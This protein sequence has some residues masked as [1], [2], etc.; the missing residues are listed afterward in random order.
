MHAFIPSCPCTCCVVPLLGVNICSAC[1]TNELIHFMVG[2]MQAGVAPNQEHHE[3]DFGR[4]RIHAQ[5]WL[6]PPRHKTRCLAIPLRAWPC[7]CRRKH[8]G[9]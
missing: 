6:F 7:E 1:A 9:N 4:T 2:P 3:A 8:A 5:T